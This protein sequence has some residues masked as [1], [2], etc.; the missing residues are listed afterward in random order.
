MNNS[1][2]P[3]MPSKV[4][5]NRDSGDVQPYQFGNDDF[6]TPGLTKRE[7]F[8]A[9]AMMGVMSADM[10][11]DVKAKE[12]AKIAVANADALLAELEKE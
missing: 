11:C 1:D 6:S 9:M 12:C 2:M 10:Y 8:A 4:S 7:H 5:V 3:A